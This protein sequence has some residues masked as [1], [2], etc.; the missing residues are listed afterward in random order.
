MIKFFR[1]IRYDL[2]E[3]NKT[4]KY[5]KYAVGEIIL[6]VIGILIAL[7]VN[8]W[9]QNRKL[10]SLEIEIL[11]DFKSS[12]EIDIIN[13]NRIIKNGNSSKN[14]MDI[15]L[16]HLEDDLPYS[17][18]LK[19]HFYNI[20]NTWTT[21]INSSVFESLKS[22]GLPLISNKELRIEIVRLYDNLSKGQKERSDRY[23][24][25]IDEASANILI[26]RFDE[27]WKS[28][29]EAWSNKNSYADTDVKAENL[30]GEM[31][32]LDYEKLKVDQEFLY[33]LKSLKNRQ[34]WLLRHENNSVLK[35]IKNVLEE[36]NIEL[37]K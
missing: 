9:S 5:F 25:L 22:E 4:G 13:F 32:P 21:E 27:L 35:A 8:D 31:I 16:A 15:I 37:E 34:F 24:D 26:T 28:N 17:D 7:Q 23:R 10:K 11:N 18:S 30:K 33:F 29:Y 12:L 14:S 2:M 3:K 19:I 20:T 1:K 6:V 36:I